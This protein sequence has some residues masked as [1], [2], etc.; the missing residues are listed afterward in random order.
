[1][2]IIIDLII[3]AFIALSVFL[4]YKKGLVSLAIGACTFIIALAVT[5]IL[6]KPVGNLIINTTGIDEMLQNTILEKVSE[7]MTEDSTQTNELIES[8][9]NGLL[10]ETSKT[11]AN[12]IVYGGVMLILFVASK[13]VLRFV[14]AVA[15]LIAKLPVI[16]QF[17]KLGGALYGILRGALIVYVILLVISFIGTVNPT[18]SLHTNINETTIAKVMYE[19]NVID[20]FL[21]QI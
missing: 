13:L 8:A 19:N 18:N 6:Y 3:I 20:I 21:N 1:M 4:G 11:L 2:G 7:V 16:N 5:L 10:P 14:K 12:N 17:N 9:K 15:N